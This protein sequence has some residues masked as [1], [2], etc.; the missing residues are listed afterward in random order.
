MPLT[1]KDFIEALTEIEREY[2]SL[3]ASSSI[4]DRKVAQ[5]AMLVLNKLKRRIKQKIVDEHGSRTK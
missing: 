3:R 2:T 4:H 5:I 1:S